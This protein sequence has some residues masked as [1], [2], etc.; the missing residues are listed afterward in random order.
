MREECPKSD[1]ES[2]HDDVSDSYDSEIVMGDRGNYHRSKSHTIT[3]E[4][5]QNGPVHSK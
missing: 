5:G 3:T 1:L 4:N 2:V